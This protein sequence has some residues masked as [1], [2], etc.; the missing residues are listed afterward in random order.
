MS[1]NQNG[2]MGWFLLFFLL[3]GWHSGTLRRCTPRNSRS[4]GNITV[5]KVWRWRKTWNPL[6]F[7]HGLPIH[8]WMGNFAWLIYYVTSSIAHCLTPGQINTNR[9]VVAQLE[10][11]GDIL[12]FIACHTCNEFQNVNFKIHCM[13]LGIITIHH[14][15]VPFATIIVIRDL[16]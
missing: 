15:L 11:L 5:R 2:S 14:D 6:L 12:K 8:T 3:L 9:I 7:R 13:S 10:R 16:L 1:C 4:F